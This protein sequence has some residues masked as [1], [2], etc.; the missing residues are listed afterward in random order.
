MELHAVDLLFYAFK[1][2]D[3]AKIGAGNGAEALGQPLHP[4]GMAHEHLLLCV[5]AAEEPGS[6]FK[7]GV[8]GA[9]FAVFTGADLAAQHVADQLHAIA[10]A[11]HRHAQVKHLFRACGGVGGIYAL[12]AAGKDNTDG[13]QGANFFDGGG[14][15]L[16]NGIYGT[17]PHPAGN[18]FLVLAAKVQD[19]NRLIHMR[20]APFPK[21]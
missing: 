7:P 12:R 3:G 14:I 15:R 18:E 9:V 11:Q 4:V 19:H 6:G 13:I 1:G 16:D 21:F 5:H 8:H 17:L 20:I 10:D 2:R